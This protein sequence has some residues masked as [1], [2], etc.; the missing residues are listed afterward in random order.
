MKY[1]KT[2]VTPQNMLDEYSF[3]A[4]WKDEVTAQVQVTKDK[5]F[6]KRYCE[7]PVRQIFA[8]NVMTRYQLNQILSMRC[9]DRNRPDAKEKLQ[10]L[11]LTDYNPHAIVR[12]T[13]GVSYNDY[14]WF[15]FPGE[16][17]CAKD[18]LVR[19]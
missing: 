16:N 5:I 4:M 15:R 6:V 11:G 12:R 14:I 17:L 18:V 9:F 3:E 19:E 10:A 2:T 13:H 8:S 1:E 7:H